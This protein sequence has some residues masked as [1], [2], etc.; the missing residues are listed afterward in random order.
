FLNS[1]DAMK[2]A[3]TLIIGTAIC[4][5]EVAAVVTDSGNGIEAVMTKQIF[6]PFFTTKP[7]G[8]VPGLGLSVCYGIVTAHGGTIEMESSALGGT[9]FTVRLPIAR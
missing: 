7:A 6:D 4:G 1:R 8:T 9:T 5:E 3:G 2:G